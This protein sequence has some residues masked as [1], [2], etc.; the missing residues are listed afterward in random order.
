MIFLVRFKTINLCILAVITKILQR[1][2]FK[3]YFLNF[4]IFLFN[5]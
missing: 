4:D 5:L 1:N 3:F 2:L